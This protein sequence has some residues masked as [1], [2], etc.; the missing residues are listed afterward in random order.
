M[1][2]SC[3]SGDP[4][5]DPMAVGRYR[6]ILDGVD[7][8]DCCYVADEELGKVWCYALNSEGEVKVLDGILVTKI[9]SGNVKVEIIK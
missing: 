4:G 5:Y 3:K 8:T 2:I 7:I 9:L 6:I 1:R